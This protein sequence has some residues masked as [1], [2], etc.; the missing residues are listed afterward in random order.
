MTLDDFKL[1]TQTMFN[2]FA[3]IKPAD[4]LRGFYEFFRSENVDDVIETSQCIARDEEKFP[5]V[6]IFAF[7]LSNLKKKRLS[8]DNHVSVNCKW[9]DGVGIVSALD[10]TKMSWAYRCHCLNAGR[11]KNYPKWFGEKHPGK[12]L[13]TEIKS[14]SQCPF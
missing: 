10:D 6:K 3:P 1:A 14:E 5:S 9:C 4:R 13:I 2:V 12:V 11:F 8:K 7:V